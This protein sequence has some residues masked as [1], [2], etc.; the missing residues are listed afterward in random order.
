MYVGIVLAVIGVCGFIGWLIW[1]EKARAKRIM[2][3]DQ[4]SIRSRR[5]S[6][7]MIPEMSTGNI[8]ET[9]QLE[10]KDTPAEFGGGGGWSHGGEKQGEINEQSKMLEHGSPPRTAELPGSRPPNRETYELE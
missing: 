2:E 9:S 10:S 8:H 4:R 5:G 7:L 3:A 1:R 6:V